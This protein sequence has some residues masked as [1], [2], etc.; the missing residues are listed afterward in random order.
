[1]QNELYFETPYKRKVYYNEAKAIID[2]FQDEESYISANYAQRFLAGFGMDDNSCELANHFNQCKKL[3]LT[4]CEACCSEKAE[5]FRGFTLC[6]SCGKLH[7]EY[8]MSDV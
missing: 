4:T 1:M 3:V 8:E 7:A 5:L 2:E 6:E